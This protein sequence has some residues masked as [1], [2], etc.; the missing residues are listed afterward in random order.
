MGSENATKHATLLLVPLL[1]LQYI[2]TPFRP[3]PNHPWA[4]TYE[5]ISA[6]TAS[7]Q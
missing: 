7:F 4:H 5:V 1:G 6:F 3:E 2:V